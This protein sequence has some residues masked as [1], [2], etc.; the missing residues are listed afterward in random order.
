MANL[1]SPSSPRLRE[2]GPWIQP[3][4]NGISFQAGSPGAD[5]LASMTTSKTIKIPA[6]PGRKPKAASTHGF[7]VPPPSQK[8]IFGSGDEEPHEPSPAVPSP[9]QL[10]FSLIQTMIEE[11]ERSRALMEQRFEDLQAREDNYSAD[12]DF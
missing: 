9:A 6:D 7:V 8:N 5:W 11:L 2:V 1:P 12:H 3:E 10:Q 4:A